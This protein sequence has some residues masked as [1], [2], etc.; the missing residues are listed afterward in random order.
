MPQ[1]TTLQYI[2]LKDLAAGL[3]VSINTVRS[4]LLPYCQRQN[5]AGEPLISGLTLLHL[6][7]RGI[8][9][10]ERAGGDESPTRTSRQSTPPHI[11]KRIV[12]R[13]N[14]HCR[15]CGRAARR[16]LQIDHILPVSRGGT[17]ADVN[18]VA[19]CPPCNGRKSNSTV[20]KA[21]MRL[22]PC[23]N[24]DAALSER[25]DRLAQGHQMPIYEDQWESER[26]KTI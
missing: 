26:G 7:Q 18:L 21:G 2:R 4:V 9:A 16:Y 3:G 5:D 15:Y 23:P 19:A 20:E 12:E 8:A 25:Q 11:R 22:R 17:D 10:D 13:D 6:M 14:G 1:R 24:G